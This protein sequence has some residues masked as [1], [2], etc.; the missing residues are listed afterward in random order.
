M[1]KGWETVDLNRLATISYGYTQ[2]AASTAIGPKFLRITDIQ[3]DALNWSEVPYCKMPHADFARYGLQSHDIVFARTGSTTG[4]SFFIEDPP[5]AV[6]A[7]YLIRVRVQSP[8]IVPKFLAMFFQTPWYW[9]V[10]RGGTAGS[11]QGG[12]NA[13]KLGAIQIPIPPLPEQRR[14]VGILDEAFAGLA[15]AEANAARNLQ[16]AREIFDSHLHAVFSQRGPCAVLSEFADEVTDGDHAPPPKASSG[17]PFITISNI[18]KRTLTI[19]FSN[20]FAVP[21]AYFRDLK[22]NRKPRVGDVLYTVTGT[23]GI[24][25]LVRQQRDFCFQRHIGLIRPNAT[26]DSSWL[27]YAL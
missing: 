25:I 18:N 24:P 16:N 12:F 10:I 14:I 17:V 19:D 27:A 15:T 5:E 4:K 20:T 2:S 3:N 13:T 21:E 6:F 23:L 1:K 22:S 26:T 9:S 11:A 7:S 8:A